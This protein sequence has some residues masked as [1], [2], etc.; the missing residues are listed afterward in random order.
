MQTK[1]KEATMN[2]HN[3]LKKHEFK[4]DKLIEILIDVQHE[5]PYN[6]ITEKEVESIAKA[7]ELPVSHVCGVMSFYT[8]LSLEKRGKYIIQVCKDVPCFINDEFNILKTLEQTLNIQ[9]GETTDDHFFTLEESACLGHCDEAPVMRI[10]DTM[11]TNLTKTKVFRILE[12]YKEG[13]LC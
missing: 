8:L 6:N 2:L 5:K 11:Y 3:I 9:C 12:Q 7:L 10:N 1:Q 13:T 4:K